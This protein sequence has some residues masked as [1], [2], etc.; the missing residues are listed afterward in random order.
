MRLG[1]MSSVMIY[2]PVKLGEK[3]EIPMP[4]LPVSVSYTLQH[5]KTCYNP[6]QNSESL[7][8]YRCTNY[9]FYERPNNE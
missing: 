2:G 3:F 4:C 5:F 9:S 1:A 6:V 7:T 8:C